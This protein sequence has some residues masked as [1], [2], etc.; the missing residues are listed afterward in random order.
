MLLRA[1]IEQFRPDFI[2][3]GNLR[4]VHTKNENQPEMAQVRDAFRALSREFGCA[5]ILIHHFRK[6]QADQNKRGSQML[7]GSGIWGAWA[8]AW[9]WVVTLGATN[10]VAIIETGSKDASGV[11]KMVVQRLDVMDGEPLAEDKDGRKVWPL[12]L[13]EVEGKGRIDESRDEVRRVGEAL[14][15]KT[16]APVTVMEIVAQTTVGER[17]VRQRVRELVKSGAWHSVNLPGSAKGYVPR[18]AETQP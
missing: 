3:V 16:G 14:H 8:E 11:G 6:S 4:E 7:A 13:V 9:M 15:E 1:E 5:F 2:I 17:T 12:I 18:P 10:D